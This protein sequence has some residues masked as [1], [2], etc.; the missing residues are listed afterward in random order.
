MAQESSSRF[1]D[2]LRA[3]RRDAELTQEELAERSG[4]SVQGIGAL[5]R[6]VIQSPWRETAL[7][8]ADALELTSE[9]REQLLEARRRTTPR[10]NRTPVAASPVAR[11]GALA[12]I[13]RA[14]EQDLISRLINRDGP[15]MLLFDGE[16]GIGKTRLLDHAVDQAQ[17]MGWMVLRGGSQQAF[18][19]HPY[20]PLIQA[21]EQSLVGQS[22]DQRRQSLRGCEWISR[23]LPEVS[24]DIVAPTSGW[25]MSPEQERRLMFSAVER[26]LTRLAEP[27]GVL[28]ALDDLQW[29]TPDAL[30]LLVAVIRATATRAHPS[31]LR[32]VAAARDTPLDAQHPFSQCIADLAHDGLVSR[33]HLEPLT[34]EHAT[35]LL[36]AALA[37]HH[38]TTPDEDE[39]AI[40]MALGRAGG[41]PFFLLGFARALSDRRGDRRQM[42][43][44]T[45]IPRDVAEMIR[46]RVKE[47]PSTA[48]GVLATAA[49][50]GRETP[51]TL[52]A[53]ACDLT[54]RQFVE[55]VEAAYASGLLVE[56]VGDSCTFRHDL[57]REVVLAD[58]SDVRKRMLHRQVAERLEA[59]PRHAQAA[60]L[61]F[62]FGRGAETNRSVVYLERTGDQACAL[63]AHAAAEGYYRDAL[64]QLNDLGEVGAS[65]RVLE[66]LGSLLMACG[67]Y[68]DA[69]DA[70]EEAASCYRQAGD[71]DGVG[72]VVAQIGWAHIRGGTGE[73]GLT[74]LEPLLTPAT[75]NGQ[76]PATQA[77]LWSAHAVL[78]FGQ[79]RYLE[80]L[81]S[82]QCAV[83]LARDANNT[84]ALAQSMRLEGLALGQ[85]GK[86]DDALSVLLETIHVAQIAGDP[87][88]FSAALNDTA[89]MYRARGELMLSWDYSA[90]ALE[91][92]E[93]LDDS[94]AK[95]FFESSHGDNAYLLGKWGTARYHYGRAVAIVRG[96]GSSWVVP[97]PFISL[98]ALD[99]AE[100][101]DEAGVRY[102]EEALTLA[103][104]GYDLQ[105]LRIGESVL[106]ERELLRGAA[107]D[108][109]RRLQPLFDSTSIHEKD[110]IAV[111]PFIGW[112]HLE[113]DNLANADA[114]LTQCLKQASA[115][116]SRLVILDALMAQARL[117][118]RQADWSAA[119]ASIEQALALARDMAYPYGELK[120]RYI[121]GALSAANQDPVQARK[122]YE[123]ALNICRRLGEALYR[124][125]IE[126]ALSQTLDR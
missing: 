79:N 45:D 6:G 2:L 114:I 102:L 3:Y 8:L 95:A 43:G 26:Y 94:T 104:R 124:P 82:A 66:K 100:G 72:R 69:A 42:I 54:E 96:M 36:L 49:V 84:T 18:G 4:L 12:L 10:T 110:S 59:D 31:R 103:R 34:I 30:R 27:V 107:A 97:Y 111:L 76:R 88:S 17:Q 87:D 108:A 40:R 83:K 56:E 63:S 113:L 13:G 46:R 71:R 112:A 50:H 20:A 86:L 65:G 64:A 99:L 48:Q 29:A 89:A 81:A 125:H 68:A 121:Y 11:P 74:R 58:L 126:R 47:L 98:G 16:P 25:Q 9:Q 14:R 32:V 38:G 23:L 91:V 39:A 44:A 105:A 118:T 73:Q 115:K 90:R 61:A 1:G 116:N 57:I 15:P 80:Q 28:L 93:Y 117:R 37:E 41:V 119:G 70:L 123:E 78:L 92:T 21:L 101:H 19:Q 7:R 85:L 51:V 67:R 77:A 62:H 24:A 52:L 35:A 75:L 106:A 55:A 22:P 60:P 53:S 120:A 33:A 122:Q 5:E 109:L